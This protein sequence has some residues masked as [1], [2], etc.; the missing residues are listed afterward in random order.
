MY[1]HVLIRYCKDVKIIPVF[2]NYRFYG[3]ESE[4]LFS[5]GCFIIDF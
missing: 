3:N 4:H 2:K 5:P 1:N